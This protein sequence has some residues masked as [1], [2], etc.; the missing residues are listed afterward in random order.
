MN[1]SPSPKPNWKP[2]VKIL[3]FVAV[4]TVALTEKL[5]TSMR[6]TP[7]LLTIA[8]AV[9]G[10]FLP[11]RA[12]LAWGI[13]LFIPVLLALIYIPNEGV[14]EQLGLVVLRAVAYCAVVLLAVLISRQR[15][16]AERQSAG[17]LAVFE[18][19]K[20]PIVVSNSDGDI[21]FAN[22]ACCDLLGRSEKELKDV[23]FFSVFT[24]PAVR[25][26]AIE[27]Y[28]KMLE[29]PPGRAAKTTVSVR[30]EQREKTY[31]ATCSVLEMENRKMLLTQLE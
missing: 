21:A 27:S 30:E 17:L 8:L 22:R 28:L 23:P 5:T 31:N 11:P 1:I 15:A 7:S 29:L 9:F 19:L 14:Y 6:V 24:H 4:L 16:D 18:A 12:V 13:F 2:W 20:T 25:G 26:K 10:V 3:P